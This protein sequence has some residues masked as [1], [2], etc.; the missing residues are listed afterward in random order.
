MC[1]PAK[2]ETPTTDSTIVQQTDSI[3]TEQ[4]ASE[5][6]KEDHPTPSLTSNSLEEIPK[7]LQEFLNAVQDPLLLANYINSTTGCYI[8]EEGPGIYPIV[9]DVKTTGD[10]NKS[11]SFTL[12]T[13]TPTLYNGYYIN[14]ADVDPCSL[15]AEGIF[16][17]DARKDSHLLLTAYQSHL[18]A[19]N[20]EMSDELK[21]K[22]NLLDASL[23]WYGAINLPGKDGE[24]NTFDI[25][26][27]SI[28]NK[29]CLAAIDTRG[30][31]I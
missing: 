18:S 4:P 22:L 31:G 26:L 17:F 23:I 1:N 25:Y 14:N 8:I 10:F 13:N 30:C 20:E 28:N 16:F 24:L 7:D 9:T 29:V 15:P 11:L 6:E 12:F 2:Q 19:A 5:E 27:A 21:I 3:T